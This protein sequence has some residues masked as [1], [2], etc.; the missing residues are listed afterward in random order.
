MA[1]S[2]A[3]VVVLALAARLQKHSVC[4]TLAHFEIVL[5]FVQAV[6]LVLL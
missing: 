3:N 4:Q 2:F 6:A 1:Q 5:D